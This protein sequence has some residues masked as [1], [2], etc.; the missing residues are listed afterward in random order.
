VVIRDNGPG[1]PPGDFRSCCGPFGQGSI[2]IKSAERG[3]G[4]G[5]PILQ[6]LMHTHDGNSN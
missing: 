5:L 1:I 3:A 2:A 6:A 4:L